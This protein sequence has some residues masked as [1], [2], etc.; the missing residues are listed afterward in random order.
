MGTSQIKS[1]NKN[2]FCEFQL[3]EWTRFMRAGDHISYNIT[4][5]DTETFNHNIKSEV[6]VVMKR[7]G[8]WGMQR[9][10]LENICTP[11]EYTFPV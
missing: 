4:D 6:Y 5:T 10:R 3:T 8:Q 11:V 7:Q 1:V 2:Y 9:T